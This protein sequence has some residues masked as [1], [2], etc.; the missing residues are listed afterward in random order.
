MCGVLQCKVNC[1]CLYSVI[2]FERFC[3]EMEE[4]SHNEYIR[5]KAEW[6]MSMTET[7]CRQGMYD[8]S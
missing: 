6:V 2:N 4:C 5:K 1:S 8:V 7:L 3:T